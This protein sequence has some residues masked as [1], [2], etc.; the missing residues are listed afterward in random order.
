MNRFQLV[1]YRFFVFFF[2]QYS[3]AFLLPV[4]W[5]VP[6]IFNIHTNQSMS[7][8]GV[9]SQACLK[10][11]RCVCVQANAG[12]LL[13]YAGYVLV[14]VNFPVGMSMSNGGVRSLMT[15]RGTCTR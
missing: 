3:H 7:S 10:S 8:G 9:R 13:G 14:I 1:W 6:V 5:Y 2:F 4:R 12:L 11:N 15:A